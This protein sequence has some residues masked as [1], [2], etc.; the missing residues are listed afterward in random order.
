MPFE[1]QSIRRDFP[2]LE[3][4]VHGH[5]IV[6]LDNAATTQAPNG[7]IGEIVEQL[8][9]RESNVH[10]GI[11]ALSEE[12]TRLM[13]AS[14]EAA[15]AFINAR[16]TAEIVF[17]S[18]TTASVNLVARSLCDHLVG[19]GD[20]IAVTQMEHHSNFIPWQQAARRNG[21]EFK[22]VPLDGDGNLRLDLLP[23]LLGGNTRIIAVCAVSN[24]L[25]TLNPLR[26]V[27]EAA[28]EVGALV[29]VDAAQAM[30]HI[31]FDV[32]ELDC[33]FLAFSAHKMMG[34]TGVGVLYGRREV[35]ERLEPIEYG[36]GMVAHADNE[37]AAFD[38]LPFRLEAGTPNIVG[39]IALSPCIDY[40]LGGPEGDPSFF[41]RAVVHEAALV[42][43]IEERLRSLPGV[44]VIGSPV[45]RTGVV[46][47]NVEGAHPFDVATLL[48][49]L[50]IAVRSGHHCAMPLLA[51]LG[52]EGAVRVSPAFYNTHEEI[53]LFIE[54]LE[55]I[56]RLLEGKR[57]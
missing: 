24:V 52:L 18:G 35:L 51:S 15:R 7:V 33:D 28:H 53:D 5:R 11:H 40:L 25:G 9:H 13:E 39:N 41:A 57:I 23:G 27:I 19:S 20:A 1:I 46:S 56:L 43:Q 37:G 48:D 8:S 32:Q 30:R 49:R 4:E 29:L 6:Y 14:R 36:G 31:R 44:Q 38:E 16:E 17:T 42:R 2:T 12:S 47:F 26:E 21:A 3:V 34:P 50:G 22:V 45:E 54:G 55:R 10:R